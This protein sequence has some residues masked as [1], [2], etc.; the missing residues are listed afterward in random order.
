[1][2]GKCD[3]YVWGK[4]DNEAESS[5]NEMRSQVYQLLHRKAGKK[6][7]KSKC[8]QEYWQPKKDKKGRKSK[9]TAKRASMCMQKEKKWH[10]EKMGKQETYFK[11]NTP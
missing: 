2:G 3:L 5:D 6:K 11:Q 4:R 10:G 9:S 7:E 8:D 1:M